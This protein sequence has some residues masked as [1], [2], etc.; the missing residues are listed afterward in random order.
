MKK[1]YQVLLAEAIFKKSYESL[2]EMQKIF[3]DYHFYD[4]RKYQ[5]EAAAAFRKAMDKKKLHDRD[6]EKILQ[7]YCDRVRI[8]DIILGIEDGLAEAKRRKTIA[9]ASGWFDTHIRKR[10]EASKN[11]VIDHIWG[12]LPIEPD[13]PWFYKLFSRAQEQKDIVFDP[14]WG[15][16]EK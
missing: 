11:Q 8:N 14:W 3:V 2:D 4:F 1:D 6:Y 15:Y 12:R 16:Q 5:K 10:H 9:Y 7:Y 13:F